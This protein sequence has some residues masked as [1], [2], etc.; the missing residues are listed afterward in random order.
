M[1]R[2][3]SKLFIYNQYWINN[4]RDFHFRSESLNQNCFSNFRQELIHIIRIKTI[5]ELTNLNFLRIVIRKG[6]EYRNYVRNSHNDSHMP[7]SEFTS[8]LETCAPN[9]S[10]NKHLNAWTDKC[11]LWKAYNTSY[12]E[13]AWLSNALNHQIRWFSDFIHH[14]LHHRRCNDVIPRNLSK[15]NCEILSYTTFAQIYK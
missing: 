14:K 3:I 9:F 7:F 6:T 12:L 15:S 4:S 11:N 5:P 13:N 1:L 8:F 2:L 10:L